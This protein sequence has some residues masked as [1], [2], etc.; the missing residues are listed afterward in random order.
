[1]SLLLGVG[2]MDCVSSG[3]R[4]DLTL[5]SGLRGGDERSTADAGR[6]GGGGRFPGDG[7]GLSSLPGDVVCA[8]GGGGV[9]DGVGVSVP[10]FLF[11]H[12]LSS[13]S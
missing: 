3:T 4:F 2:G 13:L 12:L 1:V 7:G 6:G 10:A 11:T 5:D 9:G 8:L